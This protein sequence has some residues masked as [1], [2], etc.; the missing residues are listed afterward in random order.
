MGSFIFRRVVR[1]G[2]K[3]LLQDHY[4]KIINGEEIPGYKIKQDTITLLGWNEHSIF[5]N[6]KGSFL[7]C[8]LLNLVMEIEG[9]KIVNM[10]FLPTRQGIWID[11]TAIAHVTPLP[12]KKGG[13]FLESDCSYFFQ[14]DKTPQGFVYIH[15]GYAF[16]G[17]RGLN[18]AYTQPRY[19]P[20]GKLYG[21]EDCASWIAK[22]KNSSHLYSTIDQYY[23][24]K[25]HTSV[26]VT[27]KEP[28]FGKYVAEN[29]K[30]VKIEDPLKD[31]KP[32]D[33]Y[34]HRSFPNE[35]SLMVGSGVGGHTA[36]VLGVRSSGTIV[37]LGYERN[38]PKIEGFGIGEFVLTNEFPK[39]CGILRLKE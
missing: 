35:D 19:E 9:K 17:Y 26:T 39:K 1:A 33:I 3:E 31:I 23:A 11:H 15:S 27:W 25:F 38:M 7:Q 30:P 21:L 16:G 2:T 20:A 32:G 8:A 22:I 28:Q 10:D 12:D 29:Y 34:Y 24:E 4:Y 37:S 5:G 14:D 36:L 13:P 6:S 18:E